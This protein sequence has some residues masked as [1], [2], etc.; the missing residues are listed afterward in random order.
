[1]TLSTHAPAV[2]RRW[3][4]ILVEGLDGSGVLPTALELADADVWGARYVVEFRQ[5]DAWADAIG[6]RYQIVDHDET[7]R[8]V[9]QAIIDVQS[10]P[11]V[12]G[13]PTL[14][15]VAGGTPMWRGI[16]DRIDARARAAAPSGTH[17]DAPTKAANHVW[18]EEQTTYWWQWITGARAWPGVL[19]LT[20]GA[21]VTDT[22]TYKVDVV[23]GTPQAVTATVR[24]SQGQPPALVERNDSRDPLPAGGLDLHRGLIEAVELL[25]GDLLDAPVMLP[26]DDAR[27]RM[28]A[29]G[30]LVLDGHVDAVKRV[31]RWVWDRYGLDRPVDP[32]TMALLLADLEAELTKDDGGPVDLARANPA[33]GVTVSSEAAADDLA[34]GDPADGPASTAE[35][36]GPEG[37]AVPDPLSFADLGAMAE[38]VEQ[39]G[40]TWPAVLAEATEGRATR[41]QDIE[42]DDLPALRAVLVRLLGGGS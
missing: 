27:R 22:G 1:M 20:A 14:L 21:Q 7:L 37:M 36:G 23:G 35:E 32:E 26:A 39:A 17:P 9:V 33:V 2:Q 30:R 28:A 29:Y 15:I 42:P 19:V 8:G 25:A 3:P 31:C 24:C 13:K 34:H 11:P 38:A 4:S 16:L 6:G 40:G 12:D 41:V 10:L 5:R 18:D